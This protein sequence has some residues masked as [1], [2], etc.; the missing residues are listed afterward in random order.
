MRGRLNLLSSTK[1]EL[2]TEPG[3]I[4]DGG[5]LYLQISK[6]GGTPAAW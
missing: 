3:Y 1:I 6:G 5:G 2:V 4:H